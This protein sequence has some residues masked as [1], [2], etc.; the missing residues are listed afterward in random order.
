MPIDV[1]PNVD[2]DVD[3]ALEEA[4][5]LGLEG[6]VAKRRRS[7][8]QP[9]VRSDDWLKLKLTRTQEVVIGGYRKGVG[10]REGRIR[11]L[12]VGIP[13][14]NGLRYAGRVGSGLRERDSERLLARLDDLRQDEAPFLEVPPTDVVD[15][16]WVRPVL[17]G[18]IEFGEWTRTGVARHP[19]WRGLRPD[20]RP[21]D[22]V[23]QT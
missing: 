3:Q 16:V 21:E 17:V 12:L 1:P 18:E 9:G 23:L 15:A 7:I 13:D 4:Q 5:R 20:K 19:R 10:A 22:V 8:Y 6:V 11:S 2:G 14:G